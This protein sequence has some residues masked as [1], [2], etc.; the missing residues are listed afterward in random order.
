MLKAFRMRPE[1]DHPRKNVPELGDES[2]AKFGRRILHQLERLREQRVKQLA[3]RVVEAALGAG[4]MP[5]ARGRDRKRP[6]S[7]VDPACH[8]VVVENLQRYKPEQSRLRRENRQL[9]DWAARNVR[10][11]I[12]EGCQL[13]GL[14]FVEVA[15]AYTSRQDSRTGAP[16]VRCEDVPADVLI[17]AVR[18][19]RDSNHAPPASAPPRAD[20]RFERQVRRWA[21]ELQRLS[22]NRADLK[23]RQRVLAAVIDHVDRLPAG[24]TVRLPCPGGELFASVAPST[25]ASALQADLNAAANIGLHALTDPDWMGA[26]WRVL[27]N[28]GTGQPNPEK[29]RGCPCWTDRAPIWPPAAAGERPSQVEGDGKRRRR[30]KRPKTDVY[31]WNP[32]FAP[33]WA[34]DAWLP[35]T[36]YWKQVE[37]LV[38]QRLA[39]PWTEPEN[40]F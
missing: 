6:R 28:L 3:S 2:L 35:T 14:H 34:P 38:A 17:E 27:V 40:P 31:A 13:H 10:K 16:G 33:D 7:P 26:W 21:R 32:L 36:E 8:V 18:R 25:R 22:E 1:P 4:R 20:T 12:V 30:A 11:Y 24:K 15:P 37:S 29:V 5:P 39:L 23:P 9:M 19:V